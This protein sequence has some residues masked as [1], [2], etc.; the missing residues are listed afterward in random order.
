MTGDLWCLELDDEPEKRRTGPGSKY[1]IFK[2]CY[3]I[4]EQR[5]DG[6]GF[7]IAPPPEERKDEET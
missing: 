7:Q 1:A 2:N 3:A 5:M 6:Y 4:H